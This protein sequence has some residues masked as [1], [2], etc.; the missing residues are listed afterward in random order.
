MFSIPALNSGCLADIHQRIDNK[1]KPPGSL[2]QLE[3]L[4]SQIAQIQWQGEI[5]ELEL[6]QP[7]MLV[8]A[9][10]H[11]IAA[12]D[13]SIAPQAVTQQMVLNFIHGGAAINSF[14][15]SSDM[16][17][18][19]VD[20]GMIAPIE[21]D[22]PVLMKRRVGNGTR[23]FSKEPAMTQK[24][25]QQA[26][27]SG[28]ALAQQLTLSGCNLL[29]FGEMGIGN[30]S[31]ASALLALV[32]GNEAIHVV[33]RGTGISDE[34]LVLKQQLIAQALER[35][36]GSGQNLNDA[37]VL[38]QEVGGFEIV[39]MV[40]AMLAAA[41]HR[42]VLLI[43]GFIVSVAALVASLI[44]PRVVDY[45][46]F[47]HRS[48]EGAHWDVLQ[49]LEAEPL[50]DLGLRLGEGTGAALALPLLRVAC[51]FYNN[52]ASFE[53]ASVDVVI[54][55]EDCGSDRGLAGEPVRD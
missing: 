22:S 1:T 9:A 47:A 14:C 42:S 46:V 16:E 30:T 32:K 39:Q 53:S 11:G 12:H 15:R 36:R 26:L 6:N 34:Q 17:L 50:L 2:G 38:L 24:E 29:G 23:D 48:A 41:E 54:D 25:Y 20:A 55:D 10:D 8:F 31:S 33:G 27:I 4:A 5:T 51:D 3:A 52:M 13:I 45:M 40:G 21:T 7:T 43:D 49:L 19:V 18:R 35:V 37:A 44:N 28:A